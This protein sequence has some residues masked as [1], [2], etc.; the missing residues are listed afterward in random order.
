VIGG[1]QG[2]IPKVL[3]T[4]GMA[5]AQARI[6]EVQGGTFLAAYQTLRGAGAITDKEG[7]KATDALN[8]LNKQGV[9][10]KEYRAALKEFK[11]EVGK[12]RE[13]A[14]KKAAGDYT[15]DLGVPDPLGLRK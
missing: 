3:Q 11:E 10:E 2:Y 15:P 1:I 14:R 5:G 9:S 4:E 12:L 13:I 6:D 7:A 8:R